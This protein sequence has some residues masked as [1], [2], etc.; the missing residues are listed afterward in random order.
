MLWSYFKSDS[1]DQIS[2]C[3]KWAESIQK[4]VPWVRYQELKITVS[5]LLQTAQNYNIE[6]VTS[7]GQLELTSDHADIIFL[8]YFK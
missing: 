2:M 6:T 8:G 1:N 5:S 4:L 3:S 7:T